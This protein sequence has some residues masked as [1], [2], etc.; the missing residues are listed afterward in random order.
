MLA[1]PYDAISFNWKD[2]D[3]FISEVNPAFPTRRPGVVERCNFCQERVDKGLRPACVESCK[4]NSLV[5]GD[6]EDGDSEVRKLLE[7][8]HSLRRKPELGTKPKVFYIG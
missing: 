5:F 1:C 2:P 4:E 7:S 3:P 8:H 6:L